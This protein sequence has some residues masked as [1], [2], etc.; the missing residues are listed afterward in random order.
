MRSFVKE[1]VSN[2]TIGSM[3]VDMKDQF[4][5]IGIKGSVLFN[6]FTSDRQTLHSIAGQTCRPICCSWHLVES[7]YSELI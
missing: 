1:A 7:L 4:S 5:L 6:C 3:S 2:K